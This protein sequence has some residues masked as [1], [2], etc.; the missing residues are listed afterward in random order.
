MATQENLCD[1]IQQSID[2]CEGAPQYAGIQRDVYYIA[3]SNILTWPA[4]KKTAAGADLAEYDDKS[5][6]VLKGDKKFQKIGILANKST[7]KSESQGEE[8]SSSQINKLELLHPGTGVE[9]S[10]AAAY[11]N[12][13]PSVF[14][15]ND[16]NGNLRV[17]GCQRWAS[18][19]K[20]KVA[21][22]LGQGS[23]GTASTTITV[24]APDTTPAPVYHG[25]I[26]VEGDITPTV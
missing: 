14:L 17:Y 16:A 6:F 1:I 5:S 22:D 25:E 18:E 21:Q 4:R 9:A 13:I 3:A 26:D 12:N 23:A 10:N 7:A 2:W 8:P 15:V 20:C 11:L 24:E 19:I